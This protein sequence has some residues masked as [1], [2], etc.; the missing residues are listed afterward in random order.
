MVSGANFTIVPKCAKLSKYQKWKW[1]VQKMRWHLKHHDDLFLNM[2]ISS[3][4]IHLVQTHQREIDL[5]HQN[6]QGIQNSTNFQPTLI[7]CCNFTFNWKMSLKMI[8]LDIQHNPLARMSN[9]FKNYIFLTTFTNF[10][11]FTTYQ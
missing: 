11:I 4:L 8:C 2:L 1:L 7:Q 10:V 6:C 3:T 5:F 9:I